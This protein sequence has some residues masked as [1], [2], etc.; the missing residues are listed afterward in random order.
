MFDFMRWYS[1]QPL[2][3]YGPQNY[4][5]LSIPS[6]FLVHVSSEKKTMIEKTSLTYVLPELKFLQAKQ[7]ALSNTILNSSQLK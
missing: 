7:K 1:S 5:V 2:Q 6:L 3:S 4:R